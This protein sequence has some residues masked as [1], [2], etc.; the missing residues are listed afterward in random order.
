MR[1]AACLKWADQR[2]EVDPLT[3]DVHDDARFFDVSDADRGA[4]EWALRL[5][6]AWGGEVVAVTAGPVGAET[7]LRQ[8][9]AT[10][11]HEAVRVELPPD[12]PS[13]HVAAA[14]VAAVAGCDVVLCGVHSVDR[15]SGAV[16]AHLAALLGARQALGLLA[17][18]PGAPGEVRAE[19]RL[20]FGRRER[21][22]VEAPAV[23]SLEGGLAELRRA[24]L[25]AVIAAREQA[26]TTITTVPSDRRSPVRVEHRRPYRP[27]ARTLPGPDPEAP[28]RDRIVSLTGALTERT[29]PR[30]V[31][32]EPDE[33]ADAIVEQL[34]AWGELDR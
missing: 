32:A 9:L 15:G 29:P 2:P 24:S 33:A 23:L 17:L 4:L 25:A 7:V 27:R 31:V 34:R 12:R 20:D 10:G 13:D 16:P 5:A 3:G 14:L 21:L 26:V 1:L 18:E 11:A 22:R 28:V 19:R 8:A 6:D 30:A